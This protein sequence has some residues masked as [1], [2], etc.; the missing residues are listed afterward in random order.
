MKASIALTVFI[1]ALGLPL[2]WHY[3]Q[4]LAGAR[5]RHAQLIA[6][7]STSGMINDPTRR[8]H[9]ERGTR[10]QREDKQEVAR[11]LAADFIAYGE[12]SDTPTAAEQRTLA[13]LLASAASLDTAQLKTLFAEILASKQLTGPAR[14]KLLFSLAEVASDQPQAALTM[15]T[16]SVDLTK[17]GALAKDL[18]SASLSKWA[19][20]DPTAMLGWIRENEE[21][22]RQFV[23]RTN[24]IRIVGCA[25]VNHP[26]LALQLVDQIGLDPDEKEMAFREIPERA[27]TTEDRTT[28][29]KAI[30][31]YLASLPVGIEK[32][33]AEYTLLCSVF[34]HAAC[35]GFDAATQWFESIGFVPKQL[36]ALR[37]N[38]VFINGQQ[39]G[40]WI[41][42]L[43]KMESSEVL[44]STMNDLLGRWTYVDRRGV[45]Q[46]LESIPAGPTKTLA[47]LRFVTC[48][49]EHD[50]QLAE[51]LAMTLPA[52]EN[53]GEALRRIYLNLPKD[54]EAAKQAFGKRYGFN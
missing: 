23:D 31:R 41:E 36:N 22:F 42:W 26:T 46:W 13:E 48:A 10:H 1:L 24:K 53:R 21:N 28:T 8:S 14:R 15:L 7:A 49:A 6:A 37:L 45:S 4:Q 2:G 29:F 27:V 39:P 9:A 50:P 33:Q 16:K 20:A 12:K 3:R 43:G 51:R 54:N 30:S 32:D 40:K 25:A 19:I 44:T 52:G 18:I 17:E 35:D 11:K 38:D 34:F 47:T 5:E